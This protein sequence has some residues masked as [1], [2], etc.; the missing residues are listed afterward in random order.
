VKVVEGSSS[1]VVASKSFKNVVATVAESFVGR[2]RDSCVG[3]SS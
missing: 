2:E 1:R 3:V